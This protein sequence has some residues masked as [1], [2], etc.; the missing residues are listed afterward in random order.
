MGWAWSPAVATMWRWGCRAAKSWVAA[1][2]WARVSTGWEVRAESSDQLGVIQVTMGEELV[3]EDLDGVGWE[4][5]G[6][7]GGSEDRIKDD[8]DG[9]GRSDS[10]PSS[11]LPLSEGWRENPRLTRRFRSS[12]ACQS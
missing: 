4:Q 3:V 2:A 12:R 11:S 6:A 8:R 10:L 1:S 5:V 7:G 9:G